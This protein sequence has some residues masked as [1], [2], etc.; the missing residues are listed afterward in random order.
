L[1]GMAKHLSR[2]EEDFFLTAMKRK[3]MNMM[4]KDEILNWNAKYDKEYP[5][6]TAK[7][8]ELGDKFRKTKTLTKADLREIVWWKFEWLVGRRERVLKLI[9][10]NSDKEIEVCNQVFGLTL[11]EDKFRIGI[12]DNLHGVGPA[13]SSVV[14]TFYDPK[15]YG[16][17]D[18]HVWREFF[19]KEPKGLFST[20]EYYIKL[21]SE[22][23]TIG[24][25]YDL[26][27]RTVEKAY[28]TKNYEN[29]K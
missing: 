6:W 24:N 17:F 15:N 9:E 8:K 14:L 13:L 28:F 7:E 29:S 1:N 25:K 19:G 3:W 2:R 21:L 26:N 10:K 27:A 18:I 5:K 16:V 23:R 22:L 12:L 20:S 4:D 11:L